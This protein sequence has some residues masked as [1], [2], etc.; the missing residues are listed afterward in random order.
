MYD[1]MYTFAPDSSQLPSLPPSAQTIAIGFNHRIA[2]A[3]GDESVEQVL[4]VYFSADPDDC[5]AY[6]GLER[7]RGIYAT[8]YGAT[9]DKDTKQVVR[10]KVYTYNHPIGHSDWQQALQVALTTM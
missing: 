1:K 4:D 9:Y 6:F 10:V 7:A 8:L 3:P 5:E 2:G